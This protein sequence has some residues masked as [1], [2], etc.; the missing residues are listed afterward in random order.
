MDILGIGIPELLLIFVIAL[1]VLGPKN[2]LSTTRQVSS[3][4]R[5]LLQSDMWQS[6]MNSTREIKEVQNQIIKDTGITESLNSLRQSTRVLSNPSAPKWT[7]SVQPP[8]GNPGTTPGQAANAPAALPPDTPSN[9]P[10]K[11]E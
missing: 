8:A 3:G 9:L 7:Q 4:I 5:K 11:E 10:I 6:M 1:I 2:L